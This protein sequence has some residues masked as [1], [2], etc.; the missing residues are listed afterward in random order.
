M[1]PSILKNRNFILGSSFD[2]LFRNFNIRFPAFDRETDIMWKPS[3][4]VHETEKDVTLEVELPG[5]NK[6]DIKIGVKDDILTISGERNHK[7]E[8]TKDKNFSRVERHYGKFERSFCLTENVNAA[9]I[10][11]QYKNGLLTLTLPKTEKAIP[12]EIPI[13]MN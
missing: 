6:K 2:D 11:A 8:E 7:K 5:L 12:K 9:G 1:L 3:V 10:S 13:S 4:D